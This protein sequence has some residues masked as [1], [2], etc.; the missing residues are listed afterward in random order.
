M[1][2]E[3]SSLTLSVF[4]DCVTEKFST[5]PSL[6]FVGKESITYSQLKNSVNI[7]KLYLLKS[8]IQ[9]GQKVILLGE[10]SPNWGVAYFAITTTGAIVVPI[11]S[12]FPESDINHIIRHSEAN[13][14]IVQDKF[15]HSLDLKA[16]ENIPLILSLDN[17]NPLKDEVSKSKRSTRETADY[18]PTQIK[19]ITEEEKKLLKK[20]RD[21]IEENELA[22]ILYTSG[23]T[24]HSKGVMLTH[25]NI[26]SNGLLGPEVIG[27]LPEGCVILTV[28]PLA[29]AY[30]CT[31]AFLGGLSVGAN[32]FFLDRKP[33]PKILMDALQI[34]RPQIVT[35]VPLIFEKIYHKKVI[36]EISSRKTLR[37]ISKINL[38]R[39]FL[40]RKVGKKILSSF[41]GRLISFVF[42]GA[43]INNEVEL[44]LREAKIPFAVGYGLSEA[45]PLVSGDY[46][47][48]L[49]FGSIGR[50]PDGIEVRIDN[51]KKD[52]GVGEI[53]VKGTNVMKGYYKNPDETARVLSK[54]GWLRTGDL[55]YLDEEGYLF[56]KGRQKNVYVGPSGENIFP[57][58]IEDKLRES[59]FVEEAL[60]YVEEDKIIARI[61]SDYE[62]MESVLNTAHHEIQSGDIENILERIRKE[63]NEKL[64]AFSQ[65]K[66]IWEQMEPF[67]KTPTNKIKRVLY[68][69]DY[70]S[71]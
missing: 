61:Y 49:K 35:G 29:H 63:T 21:E 59:L 57:E 17:F 16:L 3:M 32:I 4:F 67:E 68:V 42:G 41:G 58:I 1:K 34:V 9:K 25:K 70:F 8:G 54:D 5:Y 24:G 47:T 11:L 18:S 2:A 31:T 23:T 36:P 6:A 62:Y 50:I 33:S 10:N 19:P 56:I 53:M 7:L 28:L 52:T 15:Y 38:G 69:P 60:V 44:F 37:W 66:K 27:G 45:S 46:Y 48:N 13:G 40:Y 12:D 64:P 30:G 43:S 55:G 26:V 71:K 14:A 39:K 20:T 65:I 22:E 51:Q